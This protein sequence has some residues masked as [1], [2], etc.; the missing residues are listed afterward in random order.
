M[1][2]F[3]IGVYTDPLIFMY[4]IPVLFPSCSINSQILGSKQLVKFVHPISCSFPSI[5]SHKPSSEHLLDAVSEKYKSSK[6]ID[7]L[8]RQKKNKS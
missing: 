8:D 1:I 2:K 6:I 5:S 3:W 4:K 7:V